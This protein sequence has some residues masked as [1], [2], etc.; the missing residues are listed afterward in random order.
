M[1]LPSLALDS[2]F[3]AGIQDDGLAL[4]DALFDPRLFNRGD[5][6]HTLL[7]LVGIELL[8]K[9]RF[10]SRGQADHPVDEAEERQDQRTLITDLPTAPRRAPFA[11]APRLTLPAPPHAEHRLDAGL[12]VV[13]TGV[14]NDQQVTPHAEQNE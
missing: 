3:P 1:A 14:G 6:R 10:P 2:G 8:A 7:L 13:G 12:G 5:I 11:T 4:L 9:V